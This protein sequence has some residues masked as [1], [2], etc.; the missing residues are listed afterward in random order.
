MTSRCLLVMFGK[1]RPVVKE[2]RE[3]QGLVLGSS[4]GRGCHDDEGDPRGRRDS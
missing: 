3:R 2:P 4:L 1:G